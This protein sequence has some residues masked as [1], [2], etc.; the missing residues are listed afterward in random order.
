M[1]TEYDVIIIGGSFAG[2]SAAMQLA[3]ARRKILVL[4]AGM[5]RNRFAL[6]SHGF[7][8]Q[9]G[10]SPEEIMGTARKQLMAYPTVH[11]CN[12]RAEDAAQK[13]GAFEVTFRDGILDQDCEAQGKRLILAIG[14]VD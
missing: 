5:P 3:R 4:D 10:R 2:L 14:M 11:F 12:G 13:D 8:G 6:A 9:D 7:F 1:Q